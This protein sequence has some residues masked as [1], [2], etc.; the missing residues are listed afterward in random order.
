MYGRLGH[1]YFDIEQSKYVAKLNTHS[2]QGRGF[3][4][5]G[6]TASP[7]CPVRF[8]AQ[9]NFE[10]NNQKKHFRQGQPTN[11]SH[12]Q[13]NPT[14]RSTVEHK[15]SLHEQPNLQYIRRHTNTE[16]NE[17]RFDECREPHLTELARLSKNYTQLLQNF[18][19][20]RIR[21]PATHVSLHNC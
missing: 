13:I 4:Y 21:S 18:V 17:R 14:T 5:T 7:F 9:W 11:Q 1:S 15:L 20:I 10:N 6:A 3:I 8:P 19:R 16:R 2:Y 12:I